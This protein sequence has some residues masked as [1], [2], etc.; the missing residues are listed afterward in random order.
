MIEN[1]NIFCTGQQTYCSS[2]WINLYWA[3]SLPT[4]QMFWCSTGSTNYPLPIN[5]LQSDARWCCSLPQQLIVYTRICHWQI[6]GPLQHPHLATFLKHTH[7]TLVHTHTYLYTV[8]LWGH[9]ISICNLWHNG[10]LAAM[11]FKVLHKSPSSWSR[12]LHVHS[13]CALFTALTNENKLISS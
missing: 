12:H 2:I 4:R 8:R 7:K 5:P 11:H 3:I 6:N 13:P 10:A 1:I 9:A